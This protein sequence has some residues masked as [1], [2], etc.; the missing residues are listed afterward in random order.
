MGISSFAVGDCV[1]KLLAMP[2][3][4]PF[5]ACVWKDIVLG[6]EAR[7]VKWFEARF[8]GSNN[9]LIAPSGAS[10]DGWRIPQWKIFN[11]SLRVKVLEDFF[12]RSRVIILF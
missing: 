6:G 5:C 7:V 1:T 10:N 9:Y 8:K 11:N 12:S 4:T 3:S 2:V